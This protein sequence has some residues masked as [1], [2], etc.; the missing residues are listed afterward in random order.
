[1]W[2]NAENIIYITFWEYNIPQYYPNFL[3]QLNILSSKTT[4]LR[5]SVPFFRSVLPFRNCCMLLALPISREI[6]DRFW[7]SRCLNDRVKV[8]DLMRLFAGGATTPLVVKIWTKQHRLKIE[9][10]A[11]LIKI[12]RYLQAK[13]DY[14]YFIIYFA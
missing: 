7:C 12:S 3:V 9:F 8:P 11:T 1:M 14:G 13:F 5:S 4:V 10:R 6:M 2:N